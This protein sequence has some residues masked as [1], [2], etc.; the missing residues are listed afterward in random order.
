MTK[1]SSLILTLLFFVLQ[2][3]A[4]ENA[5]LES[6]GELAFDA[7]AEKIDSCYIYVDSISNIAANLDNE[8]W[9]AKA[10]FYLALCQSKSENFNEAESLM[11]RWHEYTSQNDLTEDLAHCLFH[12]T[13]I[14]RG[15]D[16]AESELESVNEAIRLFDQLGNTR[17]QAKARVAKATYMRVKRDYDESKEL[18]DKAMQAYEEIG[19]STG[20]AETYNEIALIHAWQGDNETA[21]EFFSKENDIYR[22]SNNFVGLSTSLGNV[23][24]ANLR[25]KNMDIAERYIKEAY[26]MRKKLKNPERISMSLVQLAEIHVLKNEWTRALDYSQQALAMAEEH[27]IDFNISQCYRQISYIYEKM[28]KH[29]QGLKY[30]KDYEKLKDKLLNEKIAKNGQR[31]E[32]AYKTAEKEKEIL[33]LEN[34]DKINEARIAQQRVLIGG[35]LLFLALL[36]YLFL[37]VRS[38]NKRINEQNEVISKA[39]GEKEIL[40]KEIHHRVKNNLQV[41]SSLLGLQS[42]SIEDIKAKEAI[43]EGRTRVHSM[44]LIHQNLY[45]KDNLTGIE[46]PDYLAKLS[47]N[48]YETYRVNEENTITIETDVDNIK[49]D[50]ETVIPIGLIVNELITNSLK[51]AFPKNRNGIITIALKEHHDQLT[52]TVV[53]NGIGLDESLLKEKQESFGHSLIRAFRKK[54]NA[55]LEISNQNGTHV[56]LI[57]K[58]YK[59]VA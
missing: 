45:Q 18:L 41:I 55:E 5:A 48:L 23:G 15:L 35:S 21:L 58:E 34:E 3:H 8:Y 27:E 28:G 22:A 2:L 54:L 52:L 33:R 16:R 47:K 40:L 36:S 9:I 38:K 25:L 19:D 37:R 56:E 43:Q 4:Q 26:E 24:F 31:I 32:S 39:L 10:D 14:Y 1:T 20:M 53:D 30:Y 13:Y 59:K 44:S 46:M 50:V 57:I 29:D 7:A 49:L 12:F 17:M 42:R 51:Y 6:L 11:G